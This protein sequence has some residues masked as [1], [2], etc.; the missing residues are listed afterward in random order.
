MAILEEQRRR[1]Y[2]AEMAR[3]EK[4]A[5]ERE[6]T[7][8]K[9]EH[10]E[11]QRKVAKER[12]EQLKATELGEKAFEGITEDVSVLW[13]FCVLVMNYI[14]F[15]MIK[16]AC[17]SRWVTSVSFKCLQCVCVAFHRQKSRLQ[18]QSF[19]ALVQNYATLCD[20]ELRHMTFM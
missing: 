19:K 9:Q 10:M 7:R 20:D 17:Q 2:E 13:F 11:V 16:S 18:L 15:V 12:L 3:L 8:R 5:A 6:Q 14:F 1:Q 4:E